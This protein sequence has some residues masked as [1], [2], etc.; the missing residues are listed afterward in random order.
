VVVSEASASGDRERDRERGPA[1]CGVKRVEEA[2]HE[3]NGNTENERVAQPI[4]DFVAR[5]R[6][7]RGRGRVEAEQPERREQ[8]RQATWSRAR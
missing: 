1:S 5:V 2:E 3:G 7:Q 4:G 8:S 6:P